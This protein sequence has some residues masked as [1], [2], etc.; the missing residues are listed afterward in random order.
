MP[1][2]LPPNTP[3]AA[4]YPAGTTAAPELLING[5][6]APLLNQREK[7]Q[8]DLERELAQRHG[9]AA[10]AGAA[11]P[12]GLEASPALSLAATT[13]GWSAASGAAGA[14][15]GQHV[16]SATPGLAPELSEPL[17]AALSRCSAAGGG[18][19]KAEVSC[20]API[21]SWGCVTVAAL[22]PCLAGIRR[23]WSGLSQQQR[24]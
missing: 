1:A 4:G 7:L 14:D 12:R 24:D 6:V 20:Y 11:A 3:T 16:S 13:V 23:I 10:L 8:Q 21:C 2:T 9:L 18:V 17:P 22:Q 15:G 19:M 5:T